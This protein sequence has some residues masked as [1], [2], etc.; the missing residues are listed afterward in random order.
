MGVG[1]YDAM[2]IAGL[3]RPRSFK[4][5]V[6]HPQHRMSFGIVRE[7]SKADQEFERKLAP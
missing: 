2:D 1:F 3:Q 7:M 6:G 5:T 4:Q